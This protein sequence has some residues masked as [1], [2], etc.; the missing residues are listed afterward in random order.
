MLQLMQYAANQTWQETKS[1]RGRPDK[2]ITLLLHEVIDY[3]TG[4]AGKGVG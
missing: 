1:L 2:E 3:K 4:K